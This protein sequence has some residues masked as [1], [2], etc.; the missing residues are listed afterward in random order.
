[1]KV[2]LD[3]TVLKN[4]KKRSHTVTDLRDDDGF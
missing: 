4:N 1:M 3:K 2:S